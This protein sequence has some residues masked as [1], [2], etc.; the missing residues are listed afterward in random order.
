[1]CP[2]PVVELDGSTLAGSES[3]IRLTAGNSLI[4]GFSAHSFPKYGIYISGGGSN[5]V[6]CSYVGLDVGGT[7]TDKGNAEHGV[8]IDSPDNLFGGPDAEDRNTVSGNGYSGIFVSGASA[9]DNEIRGNWAGLD[10]TGTATVANGIQ[11][12]RVYL[13]PRATIVD[14][15][16]S[17]NS[18]GIQVGAPDATIQGNLIGTDPS[19]TVDLGNVDGISVDGT[20]LRTVIGGTTAQTRNVIAGNGDAGIQISGDSTTVLGNWIGVQSDGSTPLANSRGVILLAGALGNRIGGSGLDEG[21][22]IAHNTQRGISAFGVM[23]LDNSFLSNSIHTNGNIGIDLNNDGVTPND[24]GDGDGGPN[25]QLNFPVLTSVSEGGGSLT[26][27][28]DLDVEP[29]A[30]YRV[31]FFKNPNGIDPSGNGEGELFADFV[32]VSH[33]GSGAESFSHGFSG[34]LGDVITATATR[35]TDA[36]TCAAFGSTSEF[37]APD[38]AFNRAPILSSASNQ[39]FWVGKAPTAISPLTVADTGATPSI[40]AANDIRIRIPAGFE[41]VWDTLDLSPTIGGNASWKLP[42]TISYE[43]TGKTLVIDVM[44]DFATGDSIVVSDLTFQDYTAASGPD[45]LE[46]EVNNDDAVSAVDDKTVEILAPGTPTISSFDDQSFR[47]GDPPITISEITIQDDAS[48]PTITAGND[49]RVRIPAGFN[50]SWDVSDVSAVIIGTGAGKVSS[51]VS[52]EDGGQTLVVDVLT[53]FDPGDA[54][55]VS[56]LSF[57]NFTAPSIVDHL[58]L[59]VYNDGQATAMDDKDIFIVY[60]PIPVDIVSGSD[61][62]FTV[63]DPPTEMV[64][65]R[66]TDDDFVPQITAANDIRI[67]IPAG[68]NMTWDVTDT[69]AKINA[70]GIGAVSSTVSYENGG[71]TLVLD[72]TTDFGPK[73]WIMVR[74]LSFVG[75]AA[76]SPPGRLELDVNNDGIAEDVDTRI[77]EILGSVFSVNVWPDT[78]VASGLPATGY[79]VDFT[80]SNIGTGTDS[81]DLL[82]SAN[83]GTV[84]G[85]TSMAGERLTQ[86]ANPDSARITDLPAGDNVVVTVTYDAASQPAGTVDTL[87]LVARSLANPTQQDAGL[88]I[89]TVLEEADVQVTKTGPVLVNAADTITYS[90]EVVNVGPTAAADVLIADTLPGSGTFVDASDGGT[91]SGGVV[92]WPTIVSMAADDTVTYTVRFVAP[93]TEGD[94]INLATALSSSTDPDGANNLDSLTTAV[95]AQADLQVTKTGAG[96]VLAGD[97]LTYTIEVVNAG[98][99]SAAGVLITDTLPSGATFASASNGGDTVS[100]G[101]VVEWLPALTMAANDTVTYTV[102]VIAPASGTLENIAAV[103]A[104]TADPNTGNEVDTVTTSVTEQADVKVV[105]TGPATI[106]ARDTVT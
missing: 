89:F 52:Y 56:A 25:D 92:T 100:V 82:T 30:S 66:V 38:T 63:G 102:D 48:A 31:E 84:V 42:G 37:S 20:A 2:V 72:V 105:K 24:A 80:V 81:Y 16:V 78:V 94:L 87:R 93:A 104:T 21:N 32:N 35:C 8:R 65:L 68:F 6:E 69:E 85:V 97:T 23:A 83:P 60:V 18:T 75:F 40:L 45:N 76:G 98:P 86:G 55:T 64:I 90:V 14:N 91:E 11:G 53:D 74:K 95:T 26:V 29:A 59:E 7:A 79:T 51:T 17:G 22:L 28:F 34:S 96:S 54:I 44:I 36:A 15:V 49:I 5:T 13:A 19:G 103:A 62:F 10:A 61:Q 70:T 73:D 77:K 1:V 58:E 27:N 3:G 33:S 4:R 39:T 43:D 101:N 57:T 99:S 9:T 47:V 41:M 12:I 88:L 106:D 67:T 50:M 46:L 71:R